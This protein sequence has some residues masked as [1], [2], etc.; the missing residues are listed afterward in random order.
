ML[1]KITS[2]DDIPNIYLAKCPFF[3]DFV[4]TEIHQNIFIKVFSDFPLKSFQQFQSLYQNRKTNSLQRL[5]IESVLPDSFR[6]FEFAQSISVVS[7]TNNGFIKEDD[8][9][10][11]PLFQGKDLCLSRFNLSSWSF[12]SSSSTALEMSLPRLLNLKLS[13]V[14]GLIHLPSLPVVH[15]LDLSYCRELQ[16]IPSLKKLRSLSLRDC[17][18]VSSIASEQPSLRVGII[19]H[20]RALT[21]FSFLSQAKTVSILNYPNWYYDH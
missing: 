20:C 13:H 10:F 6:D 11:F 7:I 14:T 3:F 1:S 19:S 18:L 5:H 2:L 8:Y 12:S 15:T 4:P 21:D 16:S 9:P 17:D